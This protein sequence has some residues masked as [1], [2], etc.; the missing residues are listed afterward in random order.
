MYFYRRRLE[1]TLN[2]SEVAVTPGLAAGCTPPQAPNLG[3]V[4]Q[5]EEGRKGASY[6][7][8]SAH[9][10]PHSPPDLCP[11]APPPNPGSPLLS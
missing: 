7:P 1:A 4:C 8:P 6:A 3:R 9:P 5:E 10:P 2:V 11:V